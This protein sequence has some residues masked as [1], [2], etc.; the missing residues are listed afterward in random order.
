MKPDYKKTL[1]DQLKDLK[2]EVNRQTDEYKEEKGNLGGKV[3]GYMYEKGLT[4]KV[5]KTGVIGL[6]GLLILGPTA[7]LIAGGAYAGKRFIYD[8]LFN[9]KKK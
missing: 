7:G 2:G 9:K 4:E 8:P 1:D 3:L 6:A 5:V